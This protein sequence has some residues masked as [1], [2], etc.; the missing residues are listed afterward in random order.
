M[1]RCIILPHNNYQHATSPV[2]LFWVLQTE[3]IMLTGRGANLFAE[4]IGVPS[5]PAQALVTEQ[6]RKEWQHYKKYTIG[7]KELFNSQW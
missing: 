6:E 4:S 7:V 5:V 1:F 2:F 3:H